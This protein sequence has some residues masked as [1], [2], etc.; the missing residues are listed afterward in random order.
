MFTKSQRMQPTKNG[1]T[2]LF[3]FDYEDVNVILTTQVKLRLRKLVIC[4]RRNV[5]SSPYGFK[6]VMNA[7]LNQN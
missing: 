4:I 5:A 2:F 1:A 6:P 3:R 7:P